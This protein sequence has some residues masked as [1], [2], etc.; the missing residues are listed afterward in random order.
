MH[1]GSCFCSECELINR[2]NIDLETLTPEAS[3]LESLGA[4][5]FSGFAGIK[6]PNPAYPQ[7][8]EDVGTS[9]GSIRVTGT[10]AAWIQGPNIRETSEPLTVKRPQDFKVTPIHLQA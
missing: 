10:L 2:E 9:E 3:N 5:L 8:G 6:Q 4:D 7:I 1:C